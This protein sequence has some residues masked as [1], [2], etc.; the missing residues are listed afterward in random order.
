[1]E[2]SRLAPGVGVREISENEHPV[3]NGHLVQF[4]DDDPFLVDVS[5]R[6]IS[7]GL[8]AGGGGVV[9]ATKPHLSAIEERLRARG[10]DIAAASERGQ[11][12]ALEARETLSMFMDN[13]WPDE[14][15]FTDVVGALIASAA[16]GRRPPVRVFGEMVAILWADGNGKAAI[17]LEELWNQLRQRLSFSLLCAYPMRGFDSATDGKPFHEICAEH[18]R[19]IPIESYAALPT[20]DARLRMIADLQQKANALEAAQDQLAQLLIREQAA[21]VTAESG[22]E[23]MR[24]LAAIVEGS[25]DAIVSKALSGIITSWNRGAERMF[26]YPAAEAVGRPITLII[27]A[28]RRD[29]EVE[30]LSRVGRGE[31][32]DHFETVRVRKD[33]QRIDISLS[34][35]PIRNDRGQ[36]VGAS[37]IARDI[38]DRKRLE[39]ERT[40]LLA[41]EQQARADVEAASCIKDEFLAT[42]SHELRTPLNAMLGWARV[43]R[44]GGLDGGVSARGIDVI[45]R[46]TEHL[47]QLVTDLLDVSRIITGKMALNISSVDLVHVISLAV[48]SMRPAADAKGIVIRPVLDDTVRPVRADA[49]RLQQVVW[50]LM[51]NAVKFTPQGGRVE[52]RLTALGEAARLAVTDT[53]K[54]IAPDFLPQ[55]FDR[56]RQ[57]DHT[58]TRAHAGLGLGLA[59]V[60]HLVELHGGTV[61]AESAGVGQG[62]TFV[63]ELPYGVSREVGAGGTVSSVRIRRVPIPANAL[64]GARVLIVDDS[65]DTCELLAM[66]LRRQGAAVAAAL[67]AREALALLETALPDVM[68]CDIAMPGADG[69]DLIRRLRSRPADAGGCLPAI[70]VTAYARAEDRER[71]LAAGF[72]GYISKPAEPGELIRLIQEV[73][74]KRLKA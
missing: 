60:R 56:F 57:A 21:R 11:Y 71:A 26:G 62:S 70:A 39:H 54:G 52:I 5:S 72:D 36:I 44:A 41:R 10:L 30:V 33:G 48:D 43:L 27:P 38:T 51:S 2:A 46:N 66:V 9:I 58:T 37:K 16:Q 25:D 65:A 63:V 50:N 73:V 45:E 29:E 53:G 12:I 47:G 7:A 55:V 68:V 67:S 23:A 14:R 34:V 1:M 22:Q 19:V 6:F 13:G 8:E 74:G 69:Y 17:R 31:T 35:S 20:V 42:L 28:E 3:E 15:R 18:S 40:E 24:R 49:D 4:Y 32:I 61:R 59:I 64:P